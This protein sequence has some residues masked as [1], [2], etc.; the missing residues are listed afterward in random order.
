VLAHVGPGAGT[1]LDMHAQVMDGGRVQVQRS[2]AVTFVVP[3][4]LSDF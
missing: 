1:T 4:P 3:R 2:G